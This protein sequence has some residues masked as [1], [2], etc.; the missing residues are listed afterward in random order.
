MPVVHLHRKALVALL[1][2]A[3]G[4]PGGNLDAQSAIAHALTSQDRS[5]VQHYTLTEDT[6]QKLFA[7]A[8]DAK[9]NKIPIDI[10]DP[11][12][13][14]LND[15]AAHLERSAGFRGLMQRHGLDAHT[16]LLGEYALLS[17]EFAVKYAGQPTFDSSLANP[18]NIALYR[19]HEAE[20]DALSGEDINN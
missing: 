14:S 4:T 11:N 2:C 3:V 20:L 5:A 18:A 6:Y 10:V 12:A 1:I 13:H 9:A 19:R 8:K 15:T 7:A 17:A 16:F